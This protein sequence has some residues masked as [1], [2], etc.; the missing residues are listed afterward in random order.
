MSK[1]NPETFCSEN[2]ETE[3]F[4]RSKTPFPLFPPTTKWHFQWRKCSVG[5]LSASSTNNT[6]QVQPSDSWPSGST[7]SGDAKSEPNQNQRHKLMGQICPY[8]VRFP[9]K[10][11]GIAGAQN[12]ALSAGE[13]RG[14]SRE[15]CRSFSKHK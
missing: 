4:S 7:D 3:C 13:C 15:D 8:S 1:T 5:K 11:M 2:I 14:T 6:G 10:S 12:R 9:V